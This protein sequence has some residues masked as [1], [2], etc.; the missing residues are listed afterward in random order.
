MADEWLKVRI[1]LFNDVEVFAIARALNVSQD[2]VIINLIKFW[3]WAD[4]QTEDGVIKNM[5]RKGLIELML[6]KHAATAFPIVDM[7]ALLE[8]SG[9]N[10]PPQATGESITTCGSM[11]PPDLRVFV[12]FYDELV[13]VGW[14]QFT[15]GQVIIP[16]FTRHN[17][18]SAR[19][20]SRNTKNQSSRRSKRESLPM[21]SSR[22]LSQS[23]GESIT[24]SP[25]MSPHDGDHN[26]IQDNTDTP[27]PPKGGCK[28]SRETQDAKP[29]DAKPQAKTAEVIPASP[30]ATVRTDLSS[31]VHL[32]APA[33]RLARLYEKLVTNAFGHGVKGAIVVQ[34]VHGA[35]EADIET[36]IKNYA[37]FCES[38]RIDRD[39][40][41]H[42]ANFFR[43][44]L[45]RE[46]LTP[47][48]VV[49]DDANVPPR[50]LTPEELALAE[51]E[52]LK[53]SIEVYKA[54][55]AREAQA[56]AAPS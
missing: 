3:I 45:W 44:A 20:R 56:K 29:E 6:S 7:E 16:N 5:T 27:L 21:L 50:N 2:F 23:T 11:S 22:Q 39:K 51:E 46:Y 53:R 8:S 41:K 54:R 47:V 37:H 19:A 1:G 30:V 34:L 36:S 17:T 35:T 9:G 12:R 4:T 49:A 24:R 28:E 31:N 52:E 33:T 40:R 48:E 14:L 25:H 43:D 32:N 42:G 38:R 15:D 55:K 13:R 26:T 10:S 18:R